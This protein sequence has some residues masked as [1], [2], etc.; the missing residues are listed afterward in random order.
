MADTIPELQLKSSVV[1]D[2]SIP[3]DNGV[4]TYRITPSQMHDYMR[5]R[6]IF[7]AGEISNLAIA[8][9]VGSNELTISLKTKANADASSTDPIRVA[10]RSATLTSGLFNARTITGSLSLV[11]SS[12]STLGQVS[13]QPSRIWVYLI[14]NA[15]TLEL[16]VSHKLFLETDLVSTTAEGGAGAADSATVMYSASAR[17]NVPCRLIGYIDNTQATAGTWASAGSQIQVFPA[18]SHKMPT[19]QRFTSG[20]GT[21]YKP[22]GCRAIR[23]RMVGSGG[24][25]AGS[26]TQAANNA[27]NGVDGDASTF[28]TSLLTADGGTKGSQSVTPGGRGGG[29]TINSPAFGFVWKGADGGPSVL[30]NS[31]TAGPNG[32]GTM[33]GGGASGGKENGV[34]QNAQ[35][36]TGA[37]GGAPG[38]SNLTSFIT[39]SAGGGAG[40]VDA[41]IVDPLASYAYVVA[42]AKTGG[43]AGTS[44]NAGGDSGSGLIIVDEYY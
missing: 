13:G 21:Y 37:G 39:G 36:N 3:A 19:Q 18:F 15:G 28:G 27:S 8:T 14:D 5:T 9:A 1:G 16:A 34:G 33:L 30:S 12:G 6:F 23:V 29:G 20:S 24:S 35:A 31:A 40:G 42:A 2:E 11:I 7:G 25:A 38:C 26:A 4:Q 10:F 32:G 41:W 17:S 43:A 22:A 44:G